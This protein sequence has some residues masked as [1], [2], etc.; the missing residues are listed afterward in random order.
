M[1]PR[2]QMS[3]I[4]RRV[5]NVHLKAYDSQEETV[6][7]LISARRTLKCANVLLLYFRIYRKRTSTGKH[8]TSRISFVLAGK[9]KSKGIFHLP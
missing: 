2:A 5:L 6:V 3:E 1:A 4:S 8:A 7:F 9:K